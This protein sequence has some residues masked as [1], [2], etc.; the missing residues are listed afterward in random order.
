VTAHECY[1]AAAETI[2]MQ[3]D[4]ETQRDVA[5]AARDVCH[6]AALF[7]PRDARG[8]GMRVLVTAAGKLGFVGAVPGRGYVYA[9]AHPRVGPWPPIPEVWISIANRVAGPHPWDSAILNWY[10]QGTALGWHRDQSERDTSLPIVTI[11]LGWSASWAVRAD[12]DAPIYRCP[13]HS[14]DVTLLAGESRMWLHTIERIKD[15]GYPM[16][17][18]APV[19]NG[20][21]SITLRVAG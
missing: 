21:L 12:E 10:A 19:E 2:A 17:G 7:R 9:P 8:N 3:L 4:H 5:Q 1:N 18:R 6:A 20:R 13:L 11:S 14:G 15:T 16:L